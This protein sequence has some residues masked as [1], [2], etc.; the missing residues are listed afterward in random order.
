MKEQ[1][2]DKSTFE[3]GL[4]MSVHSS[5]VKQLERSENTEIRACINE[6][7]ELGVKIKAARRVGRLCANQ[8][9]WIPLTRCKH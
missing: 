5:C 1:I 8:A 2:N 4:L 6:S 3:C 9:V 7:H